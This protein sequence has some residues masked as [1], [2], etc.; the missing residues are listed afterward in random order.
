TPMTAVPA[1]DSEPELA[2]IR[3]KVGRLLRALDRSF[4]ERETQLRVA[5]LAGAP[6]GDPGPLGALWFAVADAELRLLEVACAGEPLRAAS[7]AVAW[8]AHVLRHYGARASQPEEIPGDAGA[9][10]DD[11][12][13]LREQLALLMRR[14]V[15]EGFPVPMSGPPR[16]GRGALGLGV[17]LREQ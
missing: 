15:P 11:E 3:A 17:A 10:A 5:L 16:R 6:V 1:D 8:I 2:F 12:P 4:V 14:R 7:C 9:A 13:A